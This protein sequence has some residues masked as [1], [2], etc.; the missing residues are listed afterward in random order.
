MSN[1]ARSVIVIPAYNEAATIRAVAERCLQQCE[2]VIVVDDGSTDATITQLEGLPVRLLRNDTNSG[3]A[4]SLWKG[5]QYA[6]QQGATQV[7]TLDGDG[8][9]QPEDIPALLAAAVTHPEHLIIAARL[10]DNDQAPKARLRAN[11]IADFW[12]SWAAGQWVHDTQSGF[13]LYPGRLLSQLTPDTRRER[14]F[15]FESEILI[16]AVRRGYPCTVVPISS[17]YSSNARASHFRPVADITRIVLMVAWRLFSRGFYP[18]GL[19][20]ALKQKEQ[21]SE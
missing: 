17:S 1:E 2:Q 11:R 14:G 7:I 8:Q 16:E 9:H 19:W 6:L 12:I 5:M 18:Q 21:R 4:A 10:K 15:V 3:K 13:R 20:R